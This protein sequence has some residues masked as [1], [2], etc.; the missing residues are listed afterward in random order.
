MKPYTN[1][2]PTPKQYNFNYRLSPARMV[3]EG[4]FGQLKGRWRILLRKCES[5][6]SE[7]KIAPLACLVLHNICIDLGDTF[8]RK[9]DLTLDPVT[10]Q[11]RSRVKVRELLQM[12]ECEKIRDTC[13]QGLLVGDALAEK[14]WLEKETS[15]IK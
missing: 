1:A 9:L 14:F 4:A 15:I 11:R 2:V 12:R 6:T 3:T 10:N 13:Y 5:N 7:L 8:P